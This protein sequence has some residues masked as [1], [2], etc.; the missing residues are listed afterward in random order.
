MAKKSDFYEIAKQAMLSPQEAPVMVKQRHSNAMRIG[1]P[2]E[3]TFQENRIGLTPQAAHLLVA[4]GH[5]VLIE[6][7]AGKEAKFYD[8]DYKDAGAKITY[9]KEEVFKCDIIMKVS[10][11]SME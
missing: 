4:C 5:E 10:F 3:T 6:A 9:N 1:I 7:G 2:R 11:P 8:K